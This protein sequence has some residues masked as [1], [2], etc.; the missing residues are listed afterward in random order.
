MNSPDAVRA[1]CLAPFSRSLSGRRL[2][3]QPWERSRIIGLHS[4][5]PDLFSDWKK[6]SISMGF[7]D[8][9]SIKSS[10]AKEYTCDI[11]SGI[12]CAGIFRVGAVTRRYRSQRSELRMLRGLGAAP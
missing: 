12:V 2:V 7:S 10:D 1:A 6:R 8:A 3:C 11:C 4:M 5:T 9:V